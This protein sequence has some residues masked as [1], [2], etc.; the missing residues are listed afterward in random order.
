MSPP[1]APSLN[2]VT[3]FRS[4]GAAVLTALVV[5]AL[6]VTAV[7]LA[8][9]P[10]TPEHPAAFPSFDRSALSERQ[11]RV[12]DIA[13]A[14]F[15]AQRPGTV[16]SE[17]VE[18]PWCADFVSWVFHEAGQPLANPNSGHWRIPGV[19]TLS[20]YFQ[21]VG[22]FE[23]PEYRPRPGDVVLY[24]EPSPL[25]LHTNIV[26]VTDGAEITTVGGNEEG[27]IRIRTLSVGPDTHL[28]GYG[29]LE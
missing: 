17:G 7:L 6:A 21:A 1:G 22:R 2:W 25:G 16:Y 24:D 29:R 5:T 18:E 14:Q 10:S 12:L 11:L 4:I 3:R 23:P 28:I 19:Y 20:E 27:G 8:N 26:V 9:R 13:R 15:D